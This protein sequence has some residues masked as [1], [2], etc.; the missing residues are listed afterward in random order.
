MKLSSAPVWHYLVRDFLELYQQGSAGGS[1]KIR[2]HMAEVRRAL[3]KVFDDDPQ[4]A[5]T[6]GVEL[7]VCDHL[8]RALYAAAPYHT[9]KIARSVWSVRDNL[10]WQYGYEKVPRGLRLKFGFTQVLGAEGPIVSDRAKLGF[11]LFAPGTTYP[12]HSHKGIQE[13]YI[14][15]SGHVSENDTGV[16]SPGSLIFNPPGHS[17]RITTADREPCLLAYAWIGTPSALADQKLTF[18]R[19]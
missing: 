2:S 10:E 11:V 5:Q 17:H 14:N 8:D 7:P 16:S 12:A 13:S 4:V 18:S 9:A 3:G 6:P 19:K 1:K 15:V